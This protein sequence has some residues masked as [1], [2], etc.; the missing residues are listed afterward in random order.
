MSKKVD[1]YSNYGDFE[2]DVHTRI[3]RK[4]FGEDIGQNSWTTAEEYRRWAEA[5]GTSFTELTQ[6]LG[7]LWSE[8]VKTESIWERERR[9]V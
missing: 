2:A 5:L 6:E 8:L 9:E 3:R 7:V 1:L 4:T